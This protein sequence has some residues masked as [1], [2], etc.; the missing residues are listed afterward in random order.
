MGRISRAREVA[1]RALHDHDTRDTYIAIALDS[2]LKRSHLSSRERAHATEIV[3]GVLRQRAALDWFVEQSTGRPPARLDPWTRNL[4][5]IG[6]YEG[7]F[8]ASVPPPVAVNEAVELAKAYGGR[9]RAGLVNALLRKAFMSLPGIEFPD[10]ES[11]P[12]LHI[13]IKYSHPAWLVERWVRRFGVGET[14]QLAS[15]NNVPP[16]I[17]LRINRLRATREEV[18]EL[19]R[20]EGIEVTESTIVP[21]GIKIHRLSSSVTELGLYARGL[22]SLQDEAAMLV[23]H[24]VGPEPGEFIIDVCAAPGG[25]STHMAE[26]MGDS[27]RILSLDVHEHRLRELE[28]NL[29]R[30]GISSI[31]TLK[32]DARSAGDLYRGKAHRVLVDAPC[33]GTGVLRRRPDAR[34]RRTP[35]DLVSLVELQ[36]GILLAASQ[37][38][39]PGG[40]LVYST[41]SLEPEE[42]EGV[43]AA[44]LRESP[45]FVPR[46]VF[47]LLPE[48]FQRAYPSPETPYVYLLPHIHGTDGFFIARFDLPA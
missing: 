9:Q 12:V 26:L 29:R 39:K 43:V 34:W 21:E 11:D 18:V 47:P 38:V 35:E 5:R 24:A 3:Y 46:P 48:E 36:K 10:L 42:N 32:L 45:D 23:A 22:V 2:L 16:E 44:F 25:K 4:L 6:L 28:A 7:R 14:L 37:C 20:G 8:L 30:L 19:L 1:L 15:A 27:G 17:S 33:S 31:E 41:C 40:V 13:S